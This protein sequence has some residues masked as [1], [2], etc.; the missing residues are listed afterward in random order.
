[1]KKTIPITIANVLFYIEEDAYDTLSQ[2]LNSLQLYFAHLPEKNEV[3]SDIEG[4]IVEQFLEDKG[5]KDKIVTKIMVDKLIISMGDVK[6]FE[7]AENKDG[8]GQNDTEKEG[9]KKSL[10]RNPDDM[11]I[12]GVASG[13]A[14]YFN[15]DV[16]WVR[17]LFVLLTIGSG[18]GILIYIVLWIV[19]PLAHTPS[20]KLKMKGVR[21]TLES[22][23]DTVREKF[24][25]SEKTKT[26]LQNI[27]APLKK[28]GEIIRKSIS[29][30]IPRLGQLIGFFIV[31]GTIIGTTA[32]LGGLFTLVFNLN[33]GLID[34]PLVG[35][36]EHVNPQLVYATS[37]IGMV[38]TLVPLIFVF[39][40]G[41]SL[42]KKRNV[43][44]D[45]MTFSLIGIWCLALICGLTL[46][47]WWANQIQHLE[48][49][50][51]LTSQNHFF[52]KEDFRDLRIEYHPVQ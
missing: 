7:S 45:T 34:V 26:W 25:D 11:I 18:S 40:L 10:F 42:L 38:L 33:S 20:D 2:Y 30:I 51:T 14:V 46:L 50:Y 13:L 21:V 52:N 41:L 27:F 16:V 9:E 1:M 8:P 22:M 29:R 5:N 43:F 48:G 37:I 39:L 17:L 49:T 19:M 28:V 32:F 35:I 24:A 47:P 4:R 12:A 36:L 44:T 15:I 23:R 3:I 31:L 6:D